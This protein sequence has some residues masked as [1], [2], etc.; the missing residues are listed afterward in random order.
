MKAEALY[1][2][3]SVPNVNGRLMLTPIVSAVRV[4]R[5]GVGE[6]SEQPTVLHNVLIKIVP[7]QEETIEIQRYT[8][9]KV[10]PGL[11]LKLNKPPVAFATFIDARQVNR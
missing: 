8:P 11:G 6:V 3:T 9:K 7:E 10:D 5:N 4:Y 2:Y 1:R